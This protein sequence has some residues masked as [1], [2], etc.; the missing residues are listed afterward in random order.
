MLDKT[1]KETILVS[2]KQVDDVMESLDK[3]PFRSPQSRILWSS[4]YTTLYIVVI[5]S[6]VSNLLGH[7]FG[8][9]TALL[10]FVVSLALYVKFRQT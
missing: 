1:S 4:H 2:M 9:I 10:F 5:V 3:G 8:P 6:F 7:I